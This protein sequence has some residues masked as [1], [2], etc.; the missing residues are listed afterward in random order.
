M[1][2][3]IGKWNTPYA[4]FLSPWPDVLLWFSP[5]RIGLKCIS[6]FGHSLLL[7]PISLR[8]SA[9]PNPS[10]L[11]SS[12]SPLPTPHSLHHLG[13][14][15]AY[16]HRSLHSL[17][18]PVRRNDSH[19]P[20]PRH[21]RHQQTTSQ[22]TNLD[23]VPPLRSQS[24]RIRLGSMDTSSIAGNYAGT[25]IGGR[26]ERISGAEQG[27]GGRVGRSRVEMTLREVLR[28]PR[29]RCGRGYMA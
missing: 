22:P 21:L 16:P 4:C 3:K 5:R 2:Q 20:P 29:N 15:T 10:L 24:V 1:D 18:P 19:P 8:I 12:P 27:V 28:F 9:H 6:S 11:P 14:H 26:A 13:L 25:I 17:R 23:V 7:R